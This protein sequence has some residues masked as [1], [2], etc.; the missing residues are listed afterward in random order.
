MKNKLFYIKAVLFDFDGTL[1]KPGALDFPTIKKTLGCPAELPLLEFIENMTDP[2]QQEEAWCELER[3][4]LEAAARSEPNPQAEEM[5]AYL[6]SKGLKIGIVSRNKLGAI[7]RALRNFRTI[8][9]SDFDVI[10]SRDDPVAPK[11]S[12]KS[13]LMAAEKLGV[14]ASQSLM[15]GDFIF[16]IQAGQDAGAMTVFLDDETK[17]WKPETRSDSIK[18]SDYT[19]STLGE[20][21]DIVRLGTPLR[22]GKFP[23]DLLK[24][25]LDQFA[26][27][28]PSVLIS[29]GIG[30]DTA[31]VDVNG[32]EVLILKSDPITFA[33][34]SIG[35]YAV[36]V[37]A[38]DIATSG[39]VPRWFLTTLLFPCG[40]TPSDIFQVMHDLKNVCRKWGITLCGGHTEITDAVTRPVITGM[41][42]GTVA[43]RDLIDKRNIRPGDRV[44]LTKAVSVEGTS[45]IAREFGNILKAQGMTEAEIRECREFL[46]HISVLKEAKIAGQSRGTS[47]MHDVT[48]GGVAT[49]IEE[50]SIAGDHKI[51][52][53]MDKIPVFPHTEK[54]CQFLGIN[55]LG[56]IGS[57]SLLISCRGNSC[58][59]LISRIQQAGINISVI[60]EVLEQ[61]Q[62]IE[63]ISH[64]NPAEWPRFEVDEIT[65]L[66]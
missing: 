60:G 6:H 22:P 11:P 56:L 37:N 23:N 18:A 4:E 16:D 27:N 26:F 44:L 12:P 10:I 49:A 52:I 32:E 2:K 20:L 35:H 29:P 13:V 30:E 1:T 24:G 66:F 62:G 45:I 33:T 48:E 41:L 8:S 34:D 19:I 61:G 54:V 9:F 47:A 63:A 50:L 40:T 7:K 65:R 14:E 31:A 38:N 39:A 46:S 36:L 21:R 53:D 64:G 25:V 59:T 5:I 51:R 55:P 17:T 28:D 57:G 15:V 58:E 43:K 3:F 42:A